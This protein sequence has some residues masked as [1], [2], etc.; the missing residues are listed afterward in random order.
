MIQETLKIEV[1]GMKDYTPTSDGCSCGP[2]LTTLEMYKAF[3]SNLAMTE[4]ASLV[5]TTFVDISEE[6][7][8]N[9]PYA[10]KAYESGFSLPLTAID[11]RVRFHKNIPFNQVFKLIK[12]KLK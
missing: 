3:T 2:E 7:I 1:F 8:D 6:S 11:N 10:K 12:Q 5:T 4:Y 9:Y